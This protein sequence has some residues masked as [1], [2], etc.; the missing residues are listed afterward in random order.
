[1]AEA[2]ID[3]PRILLVYDEDYPREAYRA[4]LRKWNCDVLDVG[5]GEE[6]LDKYLEFQPE[7][8]LTT[9]ELPDMGGLDFLRRL[10]GEITRVPVIVI[11]ASGSDERVMQALDAGAFWYVEEPAKPPVLRAL[12]DRA[13]GKSREAAA[14][15]ERLEPHAIRGS[16]HSGSAMSRRQKVCIGVTLLLVVSA[17]LFPP[18]KSRWGSSYGFLF[19]PPNGLATVDLTRLCVEWLLI[20]F[21]AGGVF[22]AIRGRK[23]ATAERKTGKPSSAGKNPRRL[24][25][26]GG[27][28]ALGL[29]LVTGL[30]FWETYSYKHR[31]MP[32]IAWSPID[33]QATGISAFLKTEV[34][35]GEL[36]YQFRASP[37]SPELSLPFNIVAKSVP[38]A[39]QFTVILY[40]ADGFQLCSETFETSR[41]VDSKGALAA[42]I[43]NTRMSS[44]ALERYKQARSW[45]VI[46]NFPPLSL[47]QDELKRQLKQQPGQANQ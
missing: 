41:E 4:L 29:A 3:S 26:L 27:A 34:L 9:L 6:A 24:L 10:G 46:Y 43:S 45:N 13:I 8:V 31:S 17:A 30:V 12:L 15:S 21:V 19:L 14:N 5:S 39:K 33:I 11:T 28:I 32:P 42:L 7:V 47:V 44:C 18:W 1:M 20:L 22:L 38:S 35:D 40:D 37:S 16:A 25:I 23:G 2:T 36:L